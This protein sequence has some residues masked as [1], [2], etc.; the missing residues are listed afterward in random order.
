MSRCKFAFREIHHVEHV[1]RKAKAIAKLFDGDTGTDYHY[2]CG[3]KHAHINE[4][5]T[6]KGHKKRHGP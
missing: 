3:M 6:R 4:G 1:S 2:I 5:G